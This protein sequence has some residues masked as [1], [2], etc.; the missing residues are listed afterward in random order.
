MSY[1]FTVDCISILERY[2]DEDMHVYIIIIR[3]V[4]KRYNYEG[5]I[6]NRLRYVT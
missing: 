2:S 3:T 6:G 5:F 4:T 1:V